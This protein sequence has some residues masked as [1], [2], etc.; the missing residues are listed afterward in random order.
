MCVLV[1]F[2]ILKVFIVWMKYFDI[3]S[4]IMLVCKDF[5]LGLSALRN[6]WRPSFDGDVLCPY[7]C[8]VFYDAVSSSGVIVRVQE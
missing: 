4:S 2:R 8:E 6:L 7:V 5:C 3:R 1:L